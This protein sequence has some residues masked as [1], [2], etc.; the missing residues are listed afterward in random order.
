MPDPNR[1]FHGGV[2]HDSIPGGRSGARIQLR[3]NEI[4]AE[5]TCEGEPFFSLPFDDCDLDLGGASGRMVFCRDPEKTLTIFCEERGFMDELRD[6]SYGVLAPQLDQLT[7]LR[8]GET[9]RFRFWVIASTLLLTA[10]CIGGYFGVMAG[11]KAAV[12]AVPISVDERIGG[13]A[14][15]SLMLEERLDDNHAAT[16]LV[17]QI[18]DKLKPHSAIPDMNFRVA[19]IK[20]DQVNAF[21]VPGGQMC[22]YTGLIKKA[23][24]PEQIAGVI[25][26]EMS[27]ATLR[28]GLRAA[29]QSLGIIAAIQVMI[30]DVGGLVALGSQVAQQSI[31][32]SYSR[33]AETEAD[34][35]GARM[36]HDAKIDPKAMADFFELL[37]S[38]MGDIPGIAVWISSHPQHADRVNNIMKFQFGLPETEYQKLELD[39]KA[40]QDALQ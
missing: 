32:T 5:A 3:R 35:E 21:A 26:H 10:I 25:A 36:L 24:S 23:K 15:Q 29:G 8:K 33:G 37:K 38:E 11:A 9:H 40:A 39:L 30:G 2:F 22:V 4:V 13:M 16:V 31:L 18:V 20:S 27:H 28:H 14:M 12:K 7:R 34:L 17:R 19:V 1:T 6:G